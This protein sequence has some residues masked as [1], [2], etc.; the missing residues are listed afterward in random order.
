M[1]STFQFEN[2]L[3]FTFSIV[4]CLTSLILCFIIIDIE[5]NDQCEF[6]NLHRKFSWKIIKK[7]H[8]YCCW[9]VSNCTILPKP[10]LL[11]SDTRM[12]QSFGIDPKLSRL[13]FRVSELYKLSG[14]DPTRLEVGVP[15]I[16]GT[17]THLVISEILWFTLIFRFQQYII[18]RGVWE[19]KNVANLMAGTSREKVVSGRFGFP[20]HLGFSTVSRFSKMG[21]FTCR[22]SIAQIFSLSNKDTL[23]MPKIRNDFYY[24]K[25]R[26]KIFWT[27]CAY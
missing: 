21:I 12:L 23:V 18:T 15:V 13:Q 25:T 17:C 14:H 27:R 5:Y 7:H 22:E 20:M 16:S 10:S 19:P 24:G 6:K 11:D 2:K 9:K 26:F 3:T 4:S 8:I 1:L